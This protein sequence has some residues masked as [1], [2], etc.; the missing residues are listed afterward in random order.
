LLWDETAIVS[1]SQ[2][3]VSG[4]DDEGNTMKQLMVCGLVVLA[5]AVFGCNKSEPGGTK[6][7]K[8]PSNETFTIKAPA[9]TTTIKQGDRQTVTLTLDRGSNFKQDVTLD[10]DAPK[11]LTVTLDPKTVKASDSGTVAATVAAA[12]NAAVGDHEVKVTGKPKSGS[13]TSVTFKVKVEQHKTE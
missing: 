7:S 13:E 1:V 8:T 5:T 4:L 3:R 9:L 10:A 12:K 6:N 11:G 2:W